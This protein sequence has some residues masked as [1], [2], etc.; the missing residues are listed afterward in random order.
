MV[1]MTKYP[2]LI[3]GELI[4]EERQKERLGYRRF[5]YK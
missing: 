3:V 4:H 5:A 1:E 2:S